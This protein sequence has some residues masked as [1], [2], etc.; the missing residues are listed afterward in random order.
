MFATA[1]IDNVIFPHVE[2]KMRDRE[3]RVPAF[4]FLLLEIIILTQFVHSSKIWQEFF[5]YCNHISLIYF[6]AFY[7]KR[8]Q[9][10]IGTMYVGVI[11]QLLWLFDFTG[12]LFGVNII[13]A[14][15][16][17]FIGEFGYIK[18]V[19]LLIH[20]AIPIAVLYW[21]NGIYPRT[22]SLMYS[23][24]YIM[25]VYIFTLK[26]TPQHE[27]INCVFNPCTSLIPSWHYTAL[28][29]FYMFIL[30]FLTYY[31]SRLSIHKS[32]RREHTREL[33]MG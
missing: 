9:L 20:I 1:H 12:H 2:K 14:A 30:S 5:W 24:G 23:F 16:Y 28:W 10:I 18:I 8:T 13:N 4:F 7:F 19:G 27:N 3:T 15:D 25:P 31:L 33:S 26:F 29:P 22:Q 6:F 17:M 21:V 32:S 11:I